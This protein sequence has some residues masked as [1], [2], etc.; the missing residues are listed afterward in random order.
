MDRQRLVAGRAPRR[1]NQNNAPIAE[2]I[3]TAVDE[4]ETLRGAQKLAR[5]AIN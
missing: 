4:L 2:H 3:R 1:G 5:R